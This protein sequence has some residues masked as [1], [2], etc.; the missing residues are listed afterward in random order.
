[1]QKVCEVGR[2]WGAWKGLL[3]T[4]F[5]ALYPEQAREK[6][7]KAFPEQVSSSWNL[8]LRIVVVIIDSNPVAKMSLFIL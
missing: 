8:T 3:S 5:V 2:V 6:L 1:M 7:P 4:Y